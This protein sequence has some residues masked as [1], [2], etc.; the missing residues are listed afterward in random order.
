[1]FLT[2]RKQSTEWKLPKLKTEVPHAF[3]STYPQ[4]TMYIQQYLQ[5]L[6]NSTLWL[7]KYKL[8]ANNTPTF[9]NGLAK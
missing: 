8:W 2:W 3:I 4:Q 9:D 1:M 7:E 5:M 6:E